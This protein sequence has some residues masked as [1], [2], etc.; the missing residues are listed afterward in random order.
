MGLVGFA[1]I[2]SGQSPFASFSIKPNI[3]EKKYIL[4]FHIGVIFVVGSHVDV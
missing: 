1:N 2:P 4:V 3:D